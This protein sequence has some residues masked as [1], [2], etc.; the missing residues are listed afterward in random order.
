M[1]NIQL[2]KFLV[3]IMLGSM[4]SQTI[5]AEAEIAENSHQQ[6]TH[7]A[8]S[9]AEDNQKYFTILGLPQSATPK[10]IEYAYHKI[11]DNQQG[12]I[13]Y[14][15]ELQA[16][17]DEINTQHKAQLD[18]HQLANY[19]ADYKELQARP[20]EINKQHKAQLDSHPSVQGKPVLLKKQFG[21]KTVVIHGKQEDCYDP[22]YW[23]SGTH[24]DQYG[25]KYTK[26]TVTIVYDKKNNIKPVCPSCDQTIKEVRQAFEAVSGKKLERIKL[27]EPQEIN[28][29]NLDQQKIYDY[30]SKPDSTLKGLQAIIREERKKNNI[31][32]ISN[33]IVIGENH[34][35]LS[36]LS[37][38]DQEKAQ[39]ALAERLER[40]KPQRYAEYGM[41]AAI[42]GGIVTAIALL[43]RAACLQE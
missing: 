5:L 40:E 16:R 22:V 17:R 6:D 11:V 3:L 41:N 32:D 28:T 30:V 27:P 21:D 14:Y 12:W 4:V 20:D 31:K 38:E 37:P 26:R 29:D 1:K 36:L 18:S 43:V 15:K 35:D 23:G 25:N 19:L 13:A 10:E 24:Q 39:A 33:D 42:G 2:N 34:Q 9:A 8:K 7:E